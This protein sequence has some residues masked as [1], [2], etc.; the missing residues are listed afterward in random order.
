VCKIAQLVNGRG[1]KILR[2]PVCAEV[3]EVTKET[4][5]IEPPKILVLDEN[6][7]VRSSIAK[8]AAASKLRIATAA[9][10]GQALHL[11]DTEIFDV[12][13]AD[14][15]TTAEGDGLVAASALRDA[16]RSALVRVYA[17]FEELNRA[18]DAILKESEKAA[19]GPIVIPMLSEP[20]HQ[21]RENRDA[22]QAILERVASVLERNVFATILEWLDRVEHAGA[23]GEVALSNEE[24]TGH[25]A[26]IICEL[27]HRLRALRTPRA[28][29]FSDA[30]FQHG[31]VRHAQ[32]Y[33]IPMMVSESVALQT[34]IFETLCSRLSPEDFCFVLSD[35]KTITDECDCQLRRS[36]ASFTRQAAK[37]AA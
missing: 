3:W 24:R 37:R 17:G 6:E 1:S 11:I 4:K 28:N 26:S 13:L 9:G 8:V 30:A 19:M 23:R 5:K 32:G 18:L 12:L 21:R 29:A 16:N 25:L 10:V 31:V 27:A 33:S 7:Q 34:C 15:R 14:L 36:L 35:A 2:L 20:I 22:R